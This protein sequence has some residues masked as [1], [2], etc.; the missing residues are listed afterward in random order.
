MVSLLESINMKDRTIKMGV[1][2]NEV[3]PFNN[4]TAG[5]DDILIKPSEEFIENALRF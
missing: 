5:I 3:A 2:P 4:C 1:I